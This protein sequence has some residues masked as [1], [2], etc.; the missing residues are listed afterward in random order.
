[1]TRRRTSATQPAKP[2]RRTRA[3]ATRAAKPK[4]TA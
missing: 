2:T 4:P 1:M 3:T